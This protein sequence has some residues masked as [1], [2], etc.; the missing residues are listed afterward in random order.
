MPCHITEM[1][2]K[3]HQLKLAKILK[4]FMNVEQK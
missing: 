2:C 4:G 1:L 3:M